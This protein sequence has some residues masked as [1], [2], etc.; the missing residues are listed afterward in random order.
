MHQAWWVGEGVQGAEGM[1][2][3]GRGAEGSGAALVEAGLSLGR[4]VASTLI[5][6]PTLPCC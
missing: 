1:G 4:S 6:L 2:G 5:L 3:R